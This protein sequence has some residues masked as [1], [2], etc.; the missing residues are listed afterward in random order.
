MADQTDFLFLAF[1]LFGPQSKL[2]CYNQMHMRLVALILSLLL[3]SATLVESFHHHDDG[4]DHD[5]CPICAAALHH[6]ADIAL[7]APIV[8]YQPIVYLT[9][10]SVF[11]PETFAAQICHIPE[12]RAPPC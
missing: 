3:F 12:S 11:V 4:Q 6:S 2:F 7:P 5:D 1:I 9:F 8:I 10:F